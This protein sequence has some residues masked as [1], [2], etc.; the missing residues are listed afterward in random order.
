MTFMQTNPDAGASAEPAIRHGHD[1]AEHPVLP[2]RFELF[3]HDRR[4]AGRG[5]SLV[6]GVCQGLLDPSLDGTRCLA[7]LQFPFDGFALSLP[8]E[9]ALR[10]QNGA[11]QGEVGF[12]FVDPTGAHLP[13]LRFM[14]NSFIAGDLVQIG[15][16]LQVNTEARAGGPAPQARRGPGHG[17][18]QVVRHAG[19]VALSAGLL[20]LAAWTV[21]SR[22]LTRLEAYPAVVTA[23]GKVLR[24]PASGQLEFVN[25]DAGEGDVAF[26]LLATTGAMLSIRMPCDCALAEPPASEG[27]I[28]LAGEPVMALLEGDAAPRIRATM[29]PEG[30]RAVLG[31]DRIELVFAD[32]TVLDAALGATAAAEVAAAEPGQPVPVSLVAPVPASRIGEM[33]QLRVVRGVPLLVGALGRLGASLAG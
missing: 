5:V 9:V 11:A 12:A 27:A 3:V 6:G 17:L 28:V 22:V 26:S 19:V 21:Q 4:L 23:S 24:A 32:G 33:A 14:L 2:V 10:V 29:S 15:E 31:G 13:Q 20:A 30:L 25:P 1:G 8:V 18:R 16:V 7:M